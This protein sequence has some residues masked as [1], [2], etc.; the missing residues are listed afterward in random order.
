MKK[1]T[2]LVPSQQGN[3]KEG[4]K[5]QLDIEV[6]FKEEKVLLYK[7]VSN[8]WPAM[9]LMDVIKTISEKVDDYYKAHNPN[10]S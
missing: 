10:G 9:L 1:V 3:S 2:G 4:T 6:G 8:D 5:L 7:C